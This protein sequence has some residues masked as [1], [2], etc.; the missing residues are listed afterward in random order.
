MLFRFEVQTRKRI[1]LAVAAFALA[2]MGFGCS[3]LP[4]QRAL[5]QCRFEPVGI[6]FA[7]LQSAGIDGLL[8]MRA[9]NP[10]R[11]QAKLYRMDLWL[12]HNQDTLAQ[13]ANDS[14]VHL[15]AGDSLILP[16]RLTLPFKAMPG[17]AA[18]LAGGK[19][20]ECRLIGDAYIDT[21]LGAYT[22]RKAVNRL[23]PIDLGQVR[24]RALDAMGS[25]W[26]RG[27]LP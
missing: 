12:I 25:P 22:L 21:P 7:G 6:E 18:P 9:I 27:F 14:L 20:I 5:K 10:S 2:F 3:L 17:L 26:L 1:A 13:V 19:T 16:M 15:P 11:H 4:S 8:R 23:F 24:N